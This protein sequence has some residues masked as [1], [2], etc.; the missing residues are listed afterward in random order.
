MVRIAAC[1]YGE[2]DAE[3]TGAFVLNVLIAILPGG[4][5]SIEWKSKSF[6]VVSDDDLR[7][8]N[9]SVRDVPNHVW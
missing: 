4:A 9:R 2:M 1:S 8:H 3:L 5:E 6:A 7:T